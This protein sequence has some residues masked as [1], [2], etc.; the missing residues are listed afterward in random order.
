MTLWTG[1][2]LLVPLMLMM[3]SR[4]ALA[5]GDRGRCEELQEP[6]CL[7]NLV[8]NLTLF[9]NTIGHD[10]QLE[11]SAAFPEWLSEVPE[12]SQCA[13]SARRFAC[14][15]YFPVCTI[16][17]NAIP[18]CLEMCQQARELCAADF[19]R[20]GR[21]WPEELSCDTLPPAGGNVVCFDAADRPPA[22]GYPTSAPGRASSGAASWSTTRPTASTTR[23]T[24]STTEETT[25]P[26]QP[27]D[28]WGLWSTLSQKPDN[29][30][31]VQDSV[32]RLLAGLPDR[33]E[34]LL[35]LQE[36]IM[37][38]QKRKLELEIELLQRNV[39][40]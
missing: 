34:R 3:T 14:L 21:R 26:D 5:S 27:S 39:L 8:Y 38:L 17:P 37:T 24:A 30:G 29:S 31:E 11:A 25:S 10:T 15:V 7:R 32:R 22:E 13:K 28:L 1:Q 40:Q 18:P 6:L 33:L 23:P 35:Q 19:A 16:L 20:L 2:E 4:V 12:H 9:P 36:E